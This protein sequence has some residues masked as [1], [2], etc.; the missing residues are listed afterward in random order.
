[1]ILNCVAWCDKMG[2]D[3]VRC[4]LMMFKMRVVA[5]DQNMCHSSHDASC[6]IVPVLA[7]CPR[8]LYL[9]LLYLYFFTSTLSP[10]WTQCWRQRDKLYRTVTNAALTVVK[11]GTRSERLSEDN[12]SEYFPNK[13]SNFL[14]WNVKHHNDF[15]NFMLAAKNFQSWLHA[16]SWMEWCDSPK[17]MK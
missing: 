2:S 4:G 10:E 5:T 1:M 8:N 17:C 9:T 3:V 15:N 16:Q 7:I 12:N 6:H 13:L 14:Q 11:I